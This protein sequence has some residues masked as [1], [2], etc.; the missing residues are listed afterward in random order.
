MND[1]LIL[2]IEGRPEER[3]LIREYLSAKPPFHFELKE[4]ES[5]ELALSL[6]ARDEFDVVLLDLELPDSSGLD[7]ARRVITKIRETPVI[8]LANPED[9]ALVQQVVRYGTED[10][11]EKRLLS[12]AILFKSISYAMERKKIIQAH[13]SGLPQGY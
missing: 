4:A 1:I 8:V 3:T 10:Y 11:I 5:L 2:L 13:P 12:S 6:L 9:E 7:T